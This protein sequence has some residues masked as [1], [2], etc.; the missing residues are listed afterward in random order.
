MEN[1]EKD[2]HIMRALQNESTEEED[3]A[4]FALR[5]AALVVYA[6]GV[7][8][9]FERGS[10]GFAAVAA[11]WKEMTEGALRMPAFGVSIDRLA[12]EGMQ[13]GLWAEFVFEGEQSLAGMPF[14][15]LL[16]QVVPEHC[17]FNLARLQG[18]GYDGRC[19]Y[20]DL[21]GKTMRPFADALARLV[22]QSGGAV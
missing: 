13:S 20:L 8:H 5:A 17:G 21:R 10:D 1:K 18:G 15:A 2:A 9:R 16:V 11:A 14:T 4:A 22:G 3:L 6:G 19:F 12:R 7:P